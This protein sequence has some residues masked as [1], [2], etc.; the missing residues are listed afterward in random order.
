MPF[1]FLLGH[2]V[3]LISEPSNV[4]L[5]LMMEGGGAL[6]DNNAPRGGDFIALEPL[7]GV[8]DACTNILEFNQGH[9]KRI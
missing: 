4:K 2:L 3:N 1:L 5:L 8:E 7:H 9:P 6:R